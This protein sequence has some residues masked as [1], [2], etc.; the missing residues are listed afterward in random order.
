MSE[1]IHTPR[2]D[3]EEKRV[4]QEKTVR[5]KNKGLVLLKTMPA[6]D[7][8]DEQK[9]A[10]VEDCHQF[11][12]DGTHIQNDYARY[13]TKHDIWESF[14]NPFDQNSFVEHLVARWEELRQE[15]LTKG[16]DSFDPLQYPGHHSHADSINRYVISN[17]DLLGKVLGKKGIED[18]APGM[19]HHLI[20]EFKNWDN[21]RGYVVDEAGAISKYAKGP[22]LSPITYTEKKVRQNAVLA[23][24]ELLRHIDI[25]KFTP[26]QF[27][28]W[29]PV[30]KNGISVLE[31]AAN[32]FA[33]NSSNA[34]EMADFSRK[35][36]SIKSMFSILCIKNGIQISD[37]QVFAND[38]LKGLTEA[39]SD[40]I[41]QI[42]D[43]TAE[44]YEPHWSE[45]K[46]ES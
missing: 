15:G 7:V 30:I 34:Q 18:M 20:E 33:A 17:H 43:I 37:N 44:G 39:L 21:K 27:Q 5:F 31:R 40:V 42:L 35:L 9:R 36:A 13:F 46:D 23:A 14:V 45:E 3:D 29:M 4:L 1:H 32:L 6:D 19:S 25:Q 24:N 12:L 11:F 28:E 41:V 22:E 38:D 16:L 26:Q 2:S 10:W 8:S